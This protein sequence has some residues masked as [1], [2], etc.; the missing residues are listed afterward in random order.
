MLMYCN[1][2]IRWFLVIRVAFYV[3]LQPDVIVVFLSRLGEIQ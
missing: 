2:V 3:D 1:V